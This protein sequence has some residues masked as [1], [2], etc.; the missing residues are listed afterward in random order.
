MLDGMQIA[1]RGDGAPCERDIVSNVPFELGPFQEEAED[2][3]DRVFCCGAVA[4]TLMPSGDLRR[5]LGD[6]APHVS[7]YRRDAATLVAW[8]TARPDLACEVLVRDFA[9]MF[10][11][12]PRLCSIYAVALTVVRSVG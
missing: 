12:Q 1:S 9:S 7:V 8:E 3:I 6:A 2:L 11:T 4:L 10:T 5:S